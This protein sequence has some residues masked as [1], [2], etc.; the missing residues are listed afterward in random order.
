[1]IKAL[2]AV[3]ALF[4]FMAVA[5]VAAALVF[6]IYSWWQHRGDMAACCRA[7]VG[8][9]GN[10]TCSPARTPSGWEFRIPD[11][12]CRIHGSPK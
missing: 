8:P 5:I 9:L 2:A 11:P 3:G 4:A 10:C 7:V 1:M 12:D 6:I